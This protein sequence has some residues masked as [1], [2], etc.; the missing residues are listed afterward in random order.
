MRTQ[1]ETLN[2]DLQL[3]DP[4]ARLLVPDDLLD[5]DISETDHDED[6]DV[7]RVA[8]V[9]LHPRYRVA[10]VILLLMMILVSV[11]FTLAPPLLPFS[12]TISLAL[13]F[14]TRSSDGAP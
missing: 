11:C 10:L 2:E 7:T 6:S 3:L 8:L 13:F 9:I 1:W 4:T 12:A 5:P 14:V